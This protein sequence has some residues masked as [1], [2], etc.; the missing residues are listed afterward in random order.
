[1]IG[2]KRLLQRVSLR[3]VGRRQARFDR[4]LLRR[5]LGSGGL[6]LLLVVGLGDWRVLSHDH[7]ARISQAARATRWHIV[8]VAVKA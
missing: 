4:Q 7:F 6:Q 8:C 1:M 3:H 2:W 5:G